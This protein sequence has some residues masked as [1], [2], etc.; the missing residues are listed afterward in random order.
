MEEHEANEIYISN[1]QNGRTTYI[2]K[3][4][5]KTHNLIIWS[6]LGSVAETHTDIIEVEDEKPIELTRKRM[7]YSEVK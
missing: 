5:T 1:M 3:R 7:D 2:P 4:A 6:S